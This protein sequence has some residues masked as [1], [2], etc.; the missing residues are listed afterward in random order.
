MQVHSCM[1]VNVEVPTVCK[2]LCVVL[3][4]IP[5]CGRKLRVKRGSGPDADCVLSVV[6][7]SWAQLNLP[8]CR[9]QNRG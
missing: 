6:M 7:A 5:A 2:V 3:L 8:A 1:L 9:I 4:E